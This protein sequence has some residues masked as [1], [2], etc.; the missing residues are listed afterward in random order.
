MVDS[1]LALIIQQYINS[2][3]R[4][5]PHVFQIFF[6]DAGLFRLYIPAE[7]GRANIEIPSPRAQ[8]FSSYYK[9]QRMSADQKTFSLVFN[10][11]STID[12][13]LDRITWLAKPK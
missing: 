4:I 1:A 11:D 5:G 7:A 12:F 6:T 9:D 8:L 3:E 13:Y 2:Y 10:D